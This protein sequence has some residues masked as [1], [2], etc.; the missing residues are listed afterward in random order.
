MTGFFIGLICGDRSIVFPKLFPG[1]ITICH[2]YSL[3][4]FRS[5][6]DDFYPHAGSFLYWS[7]GF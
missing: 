2:F 7:F 1:L 3:S 5:R 4:N 6:S